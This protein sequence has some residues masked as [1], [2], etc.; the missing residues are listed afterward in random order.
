MMF[1]LGTR[2]LQ[3]KNISTDRMLRKP[4]ILHSYTQIGF[5]NEMIESF[6]D[7]LTI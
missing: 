2:L 5:T 6:V 3:A 7:A 1:S 4:A